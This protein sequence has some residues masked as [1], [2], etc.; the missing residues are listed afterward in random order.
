MTSNRL[1]ILCGTALLALAACLPAQARAQAAAEPVTVDFVAVLNGVKFDPVTVDGNGGGGHAVTGNGLL[2][3]AEMALVAAV[4]RDPSIDFSARGGARHAETVAA[5]QQARASAAKD[6]APLL[7]AYPTAAEMVAGYAMVGTKES[8]ESIAHMMAMFGAPLKGDYTL[9]QGLGRHFGPEGDADGDGRTNRQEYA[10]F[11][12]G[13]TAAYVAMAL[14]PA[15]APADAG[16][17]AA[18]PPAPGNAKRKNVG[19]VLY[20]G[21]EV[22]DVFGPV[23]MWGYIPDFNVIFIAEQAGPVPSAQGVEVVAPFSFVT[24]PAL[25]ILMVPGGFGTMA[26]LENAA[27]MDYLRK[28]S[29]NA[30]Y[31]T[32]VCT[33]SA[34]LARAGLLDGKRATSNKRFFSLAAAQDPDVKWVVAARWVEDGKVFTS[35]GVSAGTDM[36]LALVARLYSREQAEALASSVEYEW[37]GEAGNDPFAQ[38]A[39]WPKKK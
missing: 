18:A 23:E 31:T 24:A 29:A 11:K 2:D 22:L 4:L 26:Q 33:G 34:L 8:F 36:A 17:T 6:L 13:G 25:D 14:D 7:G 3:A 5:W 37:K 32:S 21:F 15:R 39:D 19:I 9:S 16:A 30:E 10:A 35:S 12:E 27:L 1:K 38:F 28:S 20:P